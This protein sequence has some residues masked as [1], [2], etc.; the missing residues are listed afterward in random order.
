[1]AKNLV[2]SIKAENDLEK[3]ADYLDSHWPEKVTAKFLSSLSNL[4]NQIATNP[5]QFPLI[6][7]T[8]RYRKC[9]I[10]RQNSLYYLETKSDI[11]ILRIFD[12]RQNPKKLKT[13]P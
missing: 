3:I 1:M 2:W 8:K 11:L 6:N 4:L 5:K 13:I 10:N 7:K 12:T 9:V